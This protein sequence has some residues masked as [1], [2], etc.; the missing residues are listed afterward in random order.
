MMQIDTTKQ[1]N[2]I[3]GVSEPLNEVRITVFGEPVA[4]SRP[5]FSGHAYTPEKTRKHEEKIA[6][7]YKAK[8]GG[9]KFEKGVPIR[10]DV[11]FFLKIPKRAKK[12]DREAMM[13]GELL[14]TKKIGDVDNFLKC[15]ADALN[16][17]AFVDDSQIVEMTGR[18]LYS[19]EPRTEILI[20][21]IKR[22]WWKTLLAMWQKWNE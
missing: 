1:Q 5:R 6:L 3:Q 20:A 18:K 12:A 4:K 19:T 15:V 9:R 21:R 14:P 8:Y 2:S 7:V 17:K 22:G 11:N 16:E 10:V 13:D